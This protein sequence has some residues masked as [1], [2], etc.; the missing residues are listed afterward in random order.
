[1]PPNDPRLV[2]EGLK[3]IGHVLATFIVLQSL[4][5]GS[6]LVLSISFEPF[7][8]LKGLRLAPK[9]DYNMELGAIINEGDPVAI[10][11]VCRR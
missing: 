7:K 9:K 1:M 3:R 11:I 2:A 10:A 4:D 5:F 6:Q 8:R